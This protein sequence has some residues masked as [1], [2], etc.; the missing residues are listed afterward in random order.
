MMELEDIVTAIAADHYYEMAPQPTR[1]G[2]AIYINYMVNLVKA[3]GVISRAWEAASLCEAA[4]V[5]VTELQQKLR[6][7]LIDLLVSLAK[8]H[9]RRDDKARAF[10]ETIIAE[11]ELSPYW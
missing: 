11:F 9:P 6:V 8:T 7:A 1:Q 5:F 2:I 10:A 4:P 3:P